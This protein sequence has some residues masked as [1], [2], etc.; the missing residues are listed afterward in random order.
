MDRNN[1]ICSLIAVELLKETGPK[2]NWSE[3][4]C[5]KLRALRASEN[6]SIRIAANDLWIRNE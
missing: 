3:D 6:I 4:C 5:V 2:N 1:T